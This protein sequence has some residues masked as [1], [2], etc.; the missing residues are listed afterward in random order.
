MT[1]ASGEEVEGEL[2]VAATGV[3]PD[4]RLAVEAGLDTREGRVVVDEHMHT[5]VQNVF[6]AGDITLAHNVVAGRSVAAEHW[7][8]AAQQ[9]LVAGLTAAGYPASW[10]RVPG[11]SCTI[12][13]FTLKYRGWGSGWDSCVVSERRNGFTATYSCAGT[14]LGTL[15]ATASPAA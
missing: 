6:A 14:I 9:G 1:L 8:D 7:R 11:F 10:D 4:V 5:S 12:G 15:D 3:R 2:V 13:A